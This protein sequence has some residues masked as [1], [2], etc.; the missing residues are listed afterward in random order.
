MNERQHPASTALMRRY[1]WV[2][3]VAFAS[4][5]DYTECPAWIFPPLLSSDPDQGPSPMI[6]RRILLWT[7]LLA[8]TVSVAHGEEPD[9]AAALARIYKLGGK[10][11][12][13][14]D[15]TVVAVDLNPRATTNADLQL[16]AALH[17]VVK[18]DL[19]G[20]EISDAGIPALARFPKL[21]DLAGEYRYH[22]RR[23]QGAF[24]AARTAIAQFATHDPHDRRSH[25]LRGPNAKVGQPQVALII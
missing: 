1:P 7:M 8:S 15:K 24:Q 6:L 17:D 13:G 22:R 9:V 16:L 25:D 21:R 3:L 20:A 2:G 14:P 19:Y 23:R 10:V 4:A 12:Y 18:L 5:A 11:Q